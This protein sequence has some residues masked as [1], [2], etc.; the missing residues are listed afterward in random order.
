MVPSLASRVKHLLCIENPGCVAYDLIFGCPGWV[1]SMIHAKAFIETGI[2]KRCLVIGAETLSRVVDEHDRDSMIFSDGAGAVILE[3]TKEKG[4]VLTHRSAS[5]TKDE[6]NF[7][8]FGTSY[9][10]EGCEH[11]RFIKMEGRKIYEF[12]LNHVPKTMKACLDESGVPIE[13]LKKIFIHQANEKM[14]QAITKRFFRLYGKE[15]PEGIM[16]MNIQKLGNSS[17]ATIPTLLDMVRKGKVENQDIHRGDVVFFA[18][19]GAGMN[20]NALVYQC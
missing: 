9:H 10:P 17:V 3:K 13:R 11:T 7:L 6:T 1:Q 15:A 5:F 14:D 8:Y 20:I 19:V 2:A 16:P 12:A 4:G 18:S